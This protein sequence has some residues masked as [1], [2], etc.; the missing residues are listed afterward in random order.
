MVSVFLFIRCFVLHNLINFHFPI[1]SVFKVIDAIKRF[2][3]WNIQ[4]ESCYCTT[5]DRNSQC[6]TQSKKLI[7]SL[8]S[9]SCTKIADKMW[10]PLFINY[11][12]VFIMITRSACNNGGKGSNKGRHSVEIMDTTCIMK[13]DC[14]V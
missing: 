3:N 5:D 4:N 12:Q 13:I 1:F 7:Q 11:S 14:S 9:S 2:P 6:H 10:F 8:I